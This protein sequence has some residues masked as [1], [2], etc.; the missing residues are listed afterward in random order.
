[1]GASCL[2]RVEDSYLRGAHAEQRQGDRVPSAPTPG[3]GG[4][5][6][7]APRPE[8][9]VLMP[10]RG[11]ARTPPLGAVESP[12]VLGMKEGRQ[13]NDPDVRAAPCPP[14]RLARCPFHIWET[15]RSRPGSEGPW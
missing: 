15:A 4:M 9:A 14:G 10:G 13:I 6:Q 8:G 5:L 7:E 3:A 11:H 12:D 1:M 2:D